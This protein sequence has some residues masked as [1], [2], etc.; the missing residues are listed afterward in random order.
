VA[1]PDIFDYS[2]GEPPAHVMTVLRALDVRIK[3]VL[4]FTAL[5]HPQIDN[6]WAKRLLINSNKIERLLLADNRGHAERLLNDYARFTI[7]TAD[8][9]RVQRYSDGGGQTAPL[10]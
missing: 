10:G 1:Q 4:R 8:G 5:I 9:L 3:I 7:W 6:E 2:A